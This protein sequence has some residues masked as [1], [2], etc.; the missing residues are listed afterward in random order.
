MVFKREEKTEK[1]NSSGS[2]CL[3]HPYWGSLNL[4]VNLRFETQPNGVILQ[5]LTNENNKSKSHPY[6]IIH[7]FFVF[8][9]LLII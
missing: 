9:I 5:G 4:F 3:D 6:L 2:F 7:G 8:R 1:S